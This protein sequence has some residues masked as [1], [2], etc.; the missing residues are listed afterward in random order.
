MLTHSLCLLSVIVT[1]R[2]YDLQACGEQDMPPSSPQSLPPPAGVYILVRDTPKLGL[3]LLGLPLQQIGMTLQWVTNVTKRKTHSVCK[4]WR[5]A[6]IVLKEGAGERL[7]RGA[8]W[9]EFC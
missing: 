9:Y 8:P 1:I 3:C 4:A 6:R 5:R 2:I 7:P